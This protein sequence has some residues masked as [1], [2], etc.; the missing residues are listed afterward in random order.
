[1][2][3][4]VSN[5]S[6]VLGYS[7]FLNVVASL[8]ADEESFVSEDGVDVGGGAF[9][10]VEEGAEVEVGLL[11]VEVYFATVGLFGWEVVGEDF[12]FEALGKLVFEFDFGIERIGGGP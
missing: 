12:G 5:G 8:S 10:E 7:C 6:G 3:E 4:A 1:L 11:V 2:L 9:E